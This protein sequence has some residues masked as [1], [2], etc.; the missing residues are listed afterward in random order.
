[1]SEEQQVA[2]SRAEGATRSLRSCVC[3]GWRDGLPPSLVSEGQDPAD[4]VD[5][6]SGLGPR[7]LGES[8]LGEGGRGGAGGSDPAHP[9]RSRF[10]RQTRRSGVAPRLSAR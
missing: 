7:P 2:V 3:S 1:M 8:G 5:D 6:R 9:P 10:E 4:A